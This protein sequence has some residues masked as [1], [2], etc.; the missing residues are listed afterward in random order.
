MKIDSI[1][2]VEYYA[3]ETTRS[4]THVYVDYRKIYEIVLTEITKS[5]KRSV[6][7]STK[8]RV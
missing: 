8:G 3:E 6:I 4:I 2:T 7:P 5:L 1:L